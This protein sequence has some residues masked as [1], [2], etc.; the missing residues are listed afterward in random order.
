MFPSPL[1][2]RCPGGVDEG[3]CQ[4]CFPSPDANAPPSP[5]G[6]GDDVFDFSEQRHCPVFLR[7]SMKGA[8]NSLGALACIACEETVGLSKNLLLK[9]LLGTYSRTFSPNRLTIRAQMCENLLSTSQFLVTIRQ[10]RQSPR[11]T[12]LLAD[13]RF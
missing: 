12:V 9:R 8:L 2:R 5:R 1:G 3:A 13:M 7:S 11:A 6:R 4:R 10:V